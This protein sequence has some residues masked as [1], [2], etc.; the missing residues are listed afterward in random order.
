MALQGLGEEPKPLDL[1]FKVPPPSLCLSY[2]STYET[3]KHR[4]I[5]GG[6]EVTRLAVAALA[7]ES[8]SCR[9]HSPR[10]VS[11]FQKG[12]LRFQVR[13]GFVPG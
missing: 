8:R 1:A 6:V 9:A 5:K 10:L 12:K 4:E 11:G 13:P 2:P 7:L 3:P